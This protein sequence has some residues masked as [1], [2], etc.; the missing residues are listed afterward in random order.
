MG[1]LIVS[2]FMT[3]DGV[4]EAPGHEE[5][6][7]GRNA[8]A[9]AGTTEDQLQ[10]KIHELDDLDALLLGRV[11]Y[12]IWEAFW[13]T[14]PTDNPLADRINSMRKY[15]VSKT[16]TEARWT[17]TV[18]LSEDIPQQVAGIKQDHEGDILIGGS[19]D[20]VNSLMPHGLIDEFRLIVF[21]VVLGSGKRLFRDERD[22]SHLRLTG[23]RAF[24][25]GAVLLTYEP[26]LEAPTS[27]YVE[28]FSFTQEQVESMQAAQ[29]TDRVLASVLFT[30]IVDSTVRAA[31][32]GD[33]R[34]RQLI[35]RHDTAARDA[36]KRFHG[37]FVKSTGDGIL[38]TFDA[39]T[40]ALRCAFQLNETMAAIGLDIRAAIHTG[41]IQIREG[42]VS[43]IGVHIASRA[44]AEAKER[45]VVVT[46]TVRD[47]ATGIDLV[48]TPLGAVGLRGVPGE[49]E[50]F[51]ASTKG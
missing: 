51:E 32:L 6:R 46:R 23:T 48:F 5:H 19:V 33:R 39:P 25:S 44:L 14:A 21:P 36:V 18:I 30:D 47:L 11:T 37:R 10:Y 34:W 17:N 42:D 4:A 35:D 2:E 24:A 31:E 3:L 43:G 22:T 49:W 41:E 28:A 13:P 26:A 8:W 45:Q 29:N 9:L 27:E 1:R 15:V 40:R 16:L 20:L 7:D 50:L 38:A 12:Q